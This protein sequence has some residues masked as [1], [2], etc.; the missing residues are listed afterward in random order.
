MSDGLLF[1]RL[2]GG[3]TAPK[4]FKASGIH[5]GIKRKRPDLAVIFS[6]TPATAAAVYTTNRVH[7]APIAVSREHV[8]KGSLRAV[9][10]N[11][12]NANACTGERGLADARE[13]ARLTAE[14]LGVQLGEVAVASTGVIGVPLPMDKVAAG[15]KH[16]VSLLDESDFDAAARAI[17]TTDTVPKQIAVE[18]ELKGRPVRIGAMAKGS[19]M[20]HPNMATMLAFITTDA[21]IDKEALQHVLSRSTEKTY[22]RITVDGDTSTNDM[23]IL[24]ANGLA[25]HELLTLDDP[26][27][28]QFASALDYVNTEM[29]KAIAKDGE[30]ATKLIEVKVQ[31]A[32][33][34]AE[35][36]Q[37]AKS[38]AASNLVK[39][40]VY[41]NDANWGRILAAVGYAG[42]DI[43]PERIDV[44]IGDVQVAKGGMGIEFDEERA[45]QI[46][47]R[48]EVTLLVDLK[49]GTEQAVAWTCDLT[50]KYIEINASY[51]T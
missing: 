21:A 19:G 1:E 34:E 49:A 11:S 35:A 23:V 15:I 51:R 16:A 3:V 28:Q 17:L 48:D 42:V 10:I 9:V 38:V 33:T 30:G 7:A 12:G 25:D 36:V 5:C 41:G 27:L 50:E 29:A 6:E 20:I 47:Q 39:T 8:D 31:G 2:A 40:A 45:A 37:V 46:L 44:F 26:E 43:Q 22:N 18:I 24:L 13:M 32:N 4:G 14:A